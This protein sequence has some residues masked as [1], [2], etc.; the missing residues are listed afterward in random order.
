MVFVC[1]DLRYIYILW[2]HAYRELWVYDGFGFGFGLDWVYMGL[3]RGHGH[4]YGKSRM[5]P[6]G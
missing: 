2:G 5:I 3:R 4:G 6:L 1:E